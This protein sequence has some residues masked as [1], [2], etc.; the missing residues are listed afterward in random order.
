MTQ[1]LFFF[2]FHK[3]LFEGNS[4]LSGASSSRRA[5]FAGAGAWSLSFPVNQQYIQA[6]R[7]GL[8]WEWFGLGWEWVVGISSPFL[9]PVLSQCFP[10]NE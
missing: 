6:R 9:I 3:T 10:R 4:L 7:T 8:V 1:S 5:G 2:S